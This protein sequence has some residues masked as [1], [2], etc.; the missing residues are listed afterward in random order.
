[1]QIFDVI[2]LL[3]LSGFIF[4]GL[5]FGFIRMIG[6]LLGMALGAW[7]ASYFYLYLFS[8]I[9]FFFFGLDNL[10][11]VICFIVI[12]SFVSR[13]TSYGFAFLDRTFNLITILP[14]IRAFNRLLGI[15]LGFFV[16]STTIGLF[17]Y[18]ISKYSVLDS[19][20]GEHIVNSKFAPTFIKFA[21]VLM[22]FLSDALKM[23]KGIM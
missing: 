17:L 14:F 16:G 12:F 18:V 1:M 3:I 15:F 21:N 20:I 23:V 6:A 11:K 5:F 9:K 13:I 22:P 2:L 19:L 8:I 10:G 4:Y 7:V